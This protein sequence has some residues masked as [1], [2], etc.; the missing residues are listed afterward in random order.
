MMTKTND[1]LLFFFFGTGPI[2]IYQ[3]KHPIFTGKAEIVRY[4]LVLRVVRIKRVLVPVNSLV[5][6]KPT[7][8]GMVL[9]PLDVIVSH[10]NEEKINPFLHAKV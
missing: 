2:L 9:T 5:R 6:K 7:I 1:F 8:H 3:P 10:T 4:G